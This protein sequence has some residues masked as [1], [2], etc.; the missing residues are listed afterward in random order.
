[1]TEAEKL[2]ELYILADTFC[3]Q[4]NFELN[5]SKLKILSLIKKY[6]PAPATLLI[7]KLGIIKTNFSSSCLGLQNKNLIVCKKGKE[8]KRNRY[9][10]LTEN[11]ESVLKSFYEL[12]SKYLR[13]EDLS[14][15]KALTILNKKI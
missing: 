4:H 11:G 3:N 8:D 14:I 1:M 9:Y 5:V 6:S 10:L 2:F 12:L 13:E 15:D 7:N